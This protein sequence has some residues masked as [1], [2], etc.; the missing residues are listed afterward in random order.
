MRYK[1]IKDTLSYIIHVND[2]L[3]NDRV[4]PYNITPLL[5][6]MRN[7]INSIKEEIKKNQSEV[8]KQIKD[9]IKDGVDKKVL[10]IL[11]IKEEVLLSI[12]NE[13][14]ND[15]HDIKNNEQQE[16]KQ[17]KHTE[18]TSKSIKNKKTRKRNRKKK[19][20]EDK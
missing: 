18:D 15:V 8:Y 6:G 12:E 4:K 10:D 17:E 20:T 7:A 16:E 2:L 13:S 19:K 9:A 3:E 1:K 5:I 14:N 11:S